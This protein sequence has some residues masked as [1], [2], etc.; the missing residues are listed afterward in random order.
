MFDK[1]IDKRFVLVLQGIFYADFQ[2]ACHDACPDPVQ[3][4]RYRRYLA[5][6]INAL[7]VFF[8]H[9]LYSA[10]L[11]LYPFEAQAQLFFFAF[12]SAMRRIFFVFHNTIYPYTL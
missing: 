10:D 4:A 7:L 2:M 6:N 9:S 12:A 3:R 5:E 1:F 11:P 8:Y